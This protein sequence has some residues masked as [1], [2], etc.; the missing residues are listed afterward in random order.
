MQ[1]DKRLEAYDGNVKVGLGSHRLSEK[2]CVTRPI[3]VKLIPW[4]MSGTRDILL[5][6]SV[7]QLTQGTE[8]ENKVQ[9]AVK[10]LFLL[11]RPTFV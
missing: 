6:H 2:L 4:R 11:D 7:V 8:R 1:K 5:L 10:A 3:G 9:T